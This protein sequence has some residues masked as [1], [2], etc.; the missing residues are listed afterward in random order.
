VAAFFYS[1][2]PPKADIWTQSA[3]QG[4]L[5]SPMHAVPGCP[6]HPR[7]PKVFDRCRT[8]PPA[9][10]VRDGHAAACHLMD[11]TP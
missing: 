10:L 11:G 1:A 7:C 5:P 3:L 2:G 6:F 8:E 9:L 4:E